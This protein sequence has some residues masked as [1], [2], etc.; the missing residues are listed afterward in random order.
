LKP[1][2]QVIFQTLKQ[3][4]LGSKTKELI[5]RNN[6]FAPVCP[7]R[8]TLFENGTEGDRGRTERERIEARKHYSP[9]HRIAF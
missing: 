9:L 3:E 1:L 4:A 2:Q 8:V 5:Y 6:G 7:Q